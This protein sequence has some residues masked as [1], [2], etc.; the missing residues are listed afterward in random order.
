MLRKMLGGFGDLHIIL[1][2][3]AKMSSLAVFL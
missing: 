3:I 2:T 1:N